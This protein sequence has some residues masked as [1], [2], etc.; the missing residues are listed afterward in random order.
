[1]TFSKNYFQ[2]PP[3]SPAT[4]TVAGCGAR[5]SCILGI[6]DPA[7]GTTP[8]SAR[9]TSQAPPAH[10]RHRRSRHH[11]FDHAQIGRSPR[12]VRLHREV[13]MFF[14]IWNLPYEP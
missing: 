9:I 12:R 2:L 4:R 1:M 7:L 5:R 6:T 10:R 13:S 3:G 11:Q 14:R 8:R